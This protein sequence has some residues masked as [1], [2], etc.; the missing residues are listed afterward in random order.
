MKYFFTIDKPIPLVDLEQT[1]AKIAQGSL[2]CLAEGILSLILLSTP[3]NSYFFIAGLSGAT[4]LLFATLRFSSSKLGADVSELCAY[5]VLAWIV[6]LTL[7]L[8]YVDPTPWRSVIFAIASLKLLRIFFSD[9][10]PK[11][12][13]GIGWAIFGPVTYFH[14]KTRTTQK[15][16]LSDYSFI[17]SAIIV[18]GLG[19]Y[20]LPRMEMEIVIGLW[21]AVP[22]TYLLINGPQLINTIKDLVIAFI[23]SK[24]LSEEKSSENLHLQQ[25][26]EALKKE[27]DDLKRENNTLRQM[28]SAPKK[29]HTDLIVAY[30]ST[31]PERQWH[32]VRIAQGVARQFARQ[33]KI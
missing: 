18:G 1:S 4:L 31:I 13:R 9:F 24:Q 25:E 33:P 27:N 8:N 14:Q 22:L 11:N 23:A 16:K 15:V 30:E 3:S 2:L 28:Q 5:E 20:F 10:L 21:F 32:L 7:Y 26:L 12:R 29:H 17:F 19:G 6:A